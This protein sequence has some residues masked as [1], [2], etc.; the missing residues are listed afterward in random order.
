MSTFL[1]NK[2]ISCIIKGDILR[3]YTSEYA[4]STEPTELPPT[5]AIDQERID[6]AS[7]PQISTDKSLLKRQG[8]KSQCPYRAGRKTGRKDSRALGQTHP[9]IGRSTSSVHEPTSLVSPPPIMAGDTAPVSVMRTAPE[10]TQASDAVKCF[11]A[12]RIAACRIYMLELEM[13][14]TTH[15]KPRVPDFVDPTKV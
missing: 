3:E 9:I 4:R 7:S 10:N 6:E 14:N 12:G 15:S 13:A 11:R 8:R 2:I 1:F 5:Q